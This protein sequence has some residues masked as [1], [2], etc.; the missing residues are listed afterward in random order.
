MIES[1]LD[2]F[3][4]GKS[5][6]KVCALAVGSRELASLGIA[7][8]ISFEKNQLFFERNTRIQS[9]YI[10]HGGRSFM[11]MYSYMGDGGY[12]K[13]RTFIGRYCSIGR[14]VS[15][16]AAGHGLDC[17]STSGGNWRG[18][19]AGP[20]TEKEQAELTGH[21]RNVSYTPKSTVI[22]NDVWIGDGAV[23]LPGVEIGDGAVVG[24]N[25]VVTRDVKPYEI[26]GGVPAKTIRFR[27]RDQYI[28]K[29]MES[30][31]WNL[32]SQLLKTIPTDN[33][34]KF[35]N[36]LERVEEVGNAVETT[37]KYRQGGS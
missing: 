30:S 28:D 3:M 12:I 15:L 37:Y 16:A 35:L 11:G 31:W 20:Y 27:F 32:D 33:V 36:A 18:A 14:R 22:R 6:G 7:H 29:L 2:C 21:S 24:A 4:Y 13:D 19:K 1:K 17:L 10:S 9:P 5:M 25:A 26:V 34:L 23:V 8:H